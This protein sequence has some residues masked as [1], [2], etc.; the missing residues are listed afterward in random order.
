[1][2]LSR[3][4]NIRKY[5]HKFFF[6]VIFS[7]FTFCLLV[8][9][10]AN[11]PAIKNSLVLWVNSVVPSLFPFFVATELL[12][13]TNIIYYSGILFKNIMKPLFNVKGECSFAFIMGILSGYPIGAK[14]ACEFRNKNICS[15]VECERLLSFTN[16]S[17]PLFII[18]SVGISMFGN[19]TIGI[20]LFITHL[21]ASITV[22]HLFRF[23][24]NA[25]NKYYIEHK[26]TS[27]LEHSIKMP[28]NLSNLGEVLAESISSATS[29]IFMI[30]GFIVI[31]ACIISI[32][33]TCGI[34][35]TLTI[36]IS[37]IFDFLHINTA[38]ITPL[39][40]GFFEI[41]SGISAISNI[42]IKEISINVIFSAFLLGTGGISI[43]LQVWSIVSK[44]D[45]SI[46]PYIIGKLLQGLFAAIYTYS[47][48]S[49]FPVFNFNL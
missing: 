16:N 22:G 8:F 4:V 21:L 48:I 5:I 12:M 49:I 24:G 38:F 39:L 2:Y 20:L 44:T 26:N 10:K 43:L 9:S 7:I 23:W 1:M 42:A 17:G 15:K 34:F 33:K 46:K 40:T 11:L 30:G 47:F 29:T 13:H 37:P 27:Q 45:L 32:L 35:S 25:S 31:F 14:L 36:I 18:G 41:T 28:V 19:V 6:P 3:V